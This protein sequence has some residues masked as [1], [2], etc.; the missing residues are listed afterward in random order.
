MARTNRLT[1][2]TIAR[3]KA[4][5]ERRAA[6]ELTSLFML[7]Q[8]CGR[9]RVAEMG[10]LLGHVG[11]DCLRQVTDI[12]AEMEQAPLAAR[13]RGLDRDA[14]IAKF[15]NRFY[16]APFLR[17]IRSVADLDDTSS[18]LSLAL[19][20]LRREAEFAEAK[21][22][23][24]ERL[25]RAT[26]PPPH[27]EEAKKDLKAVKAHDRR[28]LIRQNAREQ[29]RR[30]AT[31]ATFSSGL[32]RKAAQ[33][34]AVDEARGKRQEADPQGHVAG[35]GVYMWMPTY[36][37]DHREE[38]EEAAREAAAA[39]AAYSPSSS[40]SSSSSSSRLVAVNEG[41]E[42]VQMSV[43]ERQLLLRVVTGELMVAETRPLP[44]ARRLKKAL[45]AVKGAAAFG[46]AA[47]KHHDPSFTAAKLMSAV[48]SAARPSSSG[49]HA[50]RSS[51]HADSSGGHDAS[52]G[53]GNGHGSIGQARSMRNEARDVEAKVAMTLLLEPPATHDSHTR[54]S[55][56]D[57][58]GSGGGSHRGAGGSE[59][60]GKGKVT[61]S[62]RALSLTR[63]A[64]FLA[65]PGKSPPPRSSAPSPSASPAS[66]HTLGQARLLQAT[67]G[68]PMEA[69]A[70]GPHHAMLISFGQLFT[71]GRASGSLLGHGPLVN[72]P[73]RLTMAPPSLEEFRVD[74]GGRQGSVGRGKG[75]GGGGRAGAAAAAAVPRSSFLDRRKFDDAWK[76][77]EA[78]Y[79]RRVA[80]AESRHEFDFPRTVRAFR[81]RLVR[82]WERQLFTAGPRLV[83]GVDVASSTSG[84]DG[85][86]GFGE[87]GGGGG[88]RGERRDHNHYQH[89]SLAAREAHLTRSVFG[90]PSAVA[91]RRAPF[92][93]RA[94][95]GGEG[96][97]VAV[98][99][100]SGP[101]YPHHHHHH[102]L[103]HNYQAGQGAG[104]GRNGYAP[105]TKAFSSPAT[106]AAA[107][108]GGS[109]GGGVVVVVGGGAGAAAMAQRRSSLTHGSAGGSSRRGGP[110][111]DLL[112]SRR[113][114][115]D[116]GSG[117]CGGTKKKKKN[118]KSM[119]AGGQDGG[120][121]GDFDTDALREEAAAAEAARVAALFPPQSKLFAWGSNSAGQLGIGEA[122]FLR[123]SE[124]PL[125]VPLDMAPFQRRVV[126]QVACGAQHTVATTECGAVFTWGGGMYGQLGHGLAPASD[127]PHRTH[128]YS[129]SSSSSSSSSSSASSAATSAATSASLASQQPHNDHQDQQQHL[130]RR[131]HLP[132]HD[133][134][135]PRM[136]AG[137]G[138]NRRA[139]QVACGRYHTVLL[140]GSGKVVT[141][142]SNAHGQL[143]RGQSAMEQRKK[144]DKEENALS[145]AMAYARG[146][147]G[148]SSGV[149]V[150][151][152]REGE[153]VGIGAGASS[154]GG[155]GS[156]ECARQSTDARQQPQ[157]QPLQAWGEDLESSN[158]L[159]LVVDDLS[160]EFVLRI[161]CA[162]N[163]TAVVATGSRVFV[164]GRMIMPCTLATDPA[165]DPA[166]NLHFEMGMGLHGRRQQPVVAAAAAAA[167]ATTTAPTTAAAAA[168]AAA[169]AAR[170]ARA[171]AASAEVREARRPVSV[172]MV[173]MI[174]ASRRR[175]HRRANS[176]LPL[177]ADHHGVVDGDSDAHKIAIED[178]ACS[179]SV[180]V[181]YVH[182]LADTTGHVDEPFSKR[183]GRV[184]RGII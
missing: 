175:S 177:H 110:I 43:N 104:G 98:M 25:E 72:P 36:A 161:A 69:A 75:R 39:A 81:D 54:E 181:V 107:A 28:E 58:S 140:A 120:G 183:Q 117:G 82:E 151:E 142:G 89:A 163:G 145:W 78:E 173:D 44:A 128:R 34:Q 167:A 139:T 112:A 83:G 71:W 106:P 61:G 9:V 109:G 32:Q 66:K 86:L 149:G 23:A 165:V 160:H 93:A 131:R 179:S 123:Q 15:S 16:V 7:L 162:P 138:P 158:G 60:R 174:V 27:V 49:G 146:D 76:R 155:N 38:D 184:R 134:L 1:P 41:L 101:E 97:T 148:G 37:V 135:A 90:D 172:P 2:A 14:F 180:L 122:A 126:Q 170:S 73:E 87:R 18:E 29:L 121:A 64:G 84:N 105:P 176:I 56:K 3:A 136:V 119:V 91:V 59:S 80:V 50:D 168:G 129:L 57:A 33:Q 157:Q 53:S 26:H 133:E 10:N 62:K 35:A 150:G 51:G 21:T 137:F 182:P 103:H 141:F 79:D 40:S 48:G 42:I 124:V 63:A 115:N 52:S 116:G 113:A 11:G 171:I 159:P 125:P 169:T 24:M 143:G 108:R 111:K 19:L 77:F 164:W 178:I 31:A 5:S 95:A 94:V 114:S 12:Q 30:R 152:A 46:Y 68:H 67:W 99:Y 13:R 92:K 74:L 96:H 6:R 65:A 45:V 156:S 85:G 47:A 100:S 20:S 154:D 55:G 147:S 118:K 17:R 22:E 88:G 166:S 144:R 127:E 4:R 153:G 8:R 102:H 130:H 70:L 132:S